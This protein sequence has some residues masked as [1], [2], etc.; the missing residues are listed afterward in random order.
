MPSDEAAKS[1]AAATEPVERTGRG[2]FLAPSSG[3]CALRFGNC[4]LKRFARSLKQHN[5]M[6]VF[7]PLW[8]VVGRLMRSIPLFPCQVSGRFHCSAP[9]LRPG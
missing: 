5:L 1:V 3:P 8:A 2:R 9:T 4:N 7:E 6:C